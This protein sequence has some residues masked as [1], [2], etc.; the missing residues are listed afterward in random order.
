M[1]GTAPY[2]SLFSMAPLTEDRHPSSLDYWKEADLLPGWGSGPDEGL[3]HKLLPGGYLNVNN[4]SLRM[5][6]YLTAHLST[7]FNVVQLK[8]NASS[9]VEG[10]PKDLPPNYTETSVKTR[11]GRQVR[12]TNSDSQETKE[13]SCL[14][15]S[16]DKSLL[17]VGPALILWRLWGVRDVGLFKEAVMA[18]F[19]GDG[20]IMNLRENYQADANLPQIT[21]MIGRWWTKEAL[22]QNNKSPDSLFDWPPDANFR[23]TISSHGAMVTLQGDPS[24]R[25][26]NLTGLHLQCVTIEVICL[27]F[28][29]VE[30]YSCHEVGDGQWGAK[31]NGEWSGMVRELLDGKA[32]IIVAPLDMTLL[33]SE[34][35][36]FLV[37]LTSGWYKMVMRRPNAQD[38][39]WTVYT[40]I[41][42]TGI[43]ALLMA[44]AATMVFLFY[45]TMKCKHNYPRFTIV[46]SFTAICGFACDQGTEVAFPFTSG[47]LMA[48]VIQTFFKVIGTYY[49]SVL[50]SSL[51]AGLPDPHLVTLRDVHEKSSL[52]FGLL[53]GMATIEYF[54]ESPDPLHQSVWQSIRKDNFAALSPDLPSGIERVKS[55]PYVLMDWELRLMHRYGGDCE[56]FFLP[57]SYF[58]VKSSF[59]LRKGSPYVSLL[60]MA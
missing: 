38:H 40:R 51:A 41:F 30:S 33:R 3:N 60:N 55:E 39:V 19:T 37:A 28:R 22:Q 16:L 26:R 56:L 36:D 42:S 4:W 5:M 46:E 13:T 50:V 24:T 31:L 48:F 6:A 53:K 59:A 45:F 27:L 25:R 1:P 12:S 21:Q 8:T 29:N 35:V 44:M 23:E 18:T 43:W 14:K 47:R 2:G 32:D 20:S 54:K 52:T 10:S 49:T 58:E 11:K 17:R 57:T 15:V 9:S 7:T 34:A